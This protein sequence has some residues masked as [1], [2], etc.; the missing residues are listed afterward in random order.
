[1]SLTTSQR[2]D[3]EPQRVSAHARLA[4]AQLNGRT[5]LSRL[6]QEGS[7]KIRLPRKA[8]DPLEAVLIN[9]AGGLTGGDRIS[10]SIDLGA[11]ASAAVTT[12]ACEKIY[13]ADAGRAEVNCTLRVGP[14]ARLAWLPQETIVFDGAA[15]SR[16]LDAD[17]GE[18]ARAL[19]VEATVFGRKAMGESVSRA[20]F[21]DRWRIGRNG[22]LVHAEEFAIGPDVAATLSRS[23]VTGGAIAVATVLLV[24]DDAADHLEAARRTVGG[25]GGASAWEV[26]KSG[27]LLARLFAGDSYSLRRR[28]VPLIELLNGHGGLPKM[29]SI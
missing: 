14:A 13:R 27:K 6:Y 21:Q 19:F 3:L 23:A 8:G 18:G 12:Q 4:V 16:R 29:W 1:M 20:I 2:A 7:A 15:F 24:A 25:E 22:K 26:E 17:L 11:G 10:W 9:T 28:L 5:G